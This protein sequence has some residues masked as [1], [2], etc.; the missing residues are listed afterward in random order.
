MPPI[1]SRSSKN[2]IEQEGRILLV[3][4]AIKKQEISAIREA[5]VMQVGHKIWSEGL[6][7]LGIFVMNS[8]YLE[9]YDKINIRWEV[10]Q[11]VQSSASPQFPGKLTRLNDVNCRLVVY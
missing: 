8:A 10:L 4:Q 7:V 5:F 2:S 9:H 11:H 6:S 1:R 3:I